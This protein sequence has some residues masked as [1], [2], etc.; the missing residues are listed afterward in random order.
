MFH[1][2][3]YAKVKYLSEADIMVIYGLTDLIFSANSWCW[4]STE[5]SSIYLAQVDAT[6]TLCLL[7]FGKYPMSISM[8]LQVI[9]TG[10]VSLFFPHMNA[11]IVY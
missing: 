7:T 5:S 6:V 9:L 1:P 3:T 11:K 8:E 4:L 10:G 2:I